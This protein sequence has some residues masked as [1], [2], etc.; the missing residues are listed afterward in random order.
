MHFHTQML[1]IIYADTFLPPVCIM[2]FTCLLQVMSRIP[3]EQWESGQC[4]LGSVSDQPLPPI[5]KPLHRPRLKKGFS[6]PM[7][8]KSVQKP[9]V[10][11][12]RYIVHTYIRT[13]STYNV[14]T[15]LDYPCAPSTYSTY[16]CMY[17]ILCYAI[18]RYLAIS[19]MYVYMWYVAWATSKEKQ[20]TH[21]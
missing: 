16:T 14:R 21:S 15:Y 4:F 3:A 12:H 19:L 20:C 9:K 8:P 18:I 1:Y 17:T 6:N 2:L 10:L 11:N 5:S 7:D 13:Y